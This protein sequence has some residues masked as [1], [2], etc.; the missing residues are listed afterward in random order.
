MADD[1]GEFTSPVQTYNPLRL[2]VAK[3]LR[4]DENYC[5]I[6]SF[7]DLSAILA[8]AINNNN[9]VYCNADLLQDAF[10]NGGIKKYTFG[11]SMFTYFDGD[12]SVMIVSLSKQT[13][14]ARLG[15]REM[16]T[17][18]IGCFPTRNAAILANNVTSWDVGSLVADLVR[19]DIGLVMT[20]RKCWLR[21]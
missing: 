12:D 13:G 9:D 21:L 16:T 11:I 3:I 17:A 18:T 19:H 8:A 5:H 4:R 2:L 10:K 20:I 14:S 1:V 15:D 7:D 6:Y